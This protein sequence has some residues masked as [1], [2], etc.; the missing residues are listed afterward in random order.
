MKTK[1]DSEV[2]AKINKQAAA[3]KMYLYISICGNPSVH[4]QVWWGM[5]LLLRVLLHS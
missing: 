1:P 2:A 3:T 5:G 4:M